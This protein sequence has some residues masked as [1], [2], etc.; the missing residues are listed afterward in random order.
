MWSY[1]GCRGYAPA[2]PVWYW[3]QHA[4]PSHWAEKELSASTPAPSAQATVGGVGSALLSLDYLKDPGAES[5]SVKVTITDPSGTGE[6]NIT[7]IPDGFQAKS[8]FAAAIPGA[9]VKMDVTGCTAQLKWYE[10]V[11]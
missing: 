11:L 8:E 5:S 9:T 10:R 4:H 7:T 1:T 2:Y 6:W 3:P